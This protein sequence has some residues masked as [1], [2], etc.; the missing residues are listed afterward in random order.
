MWPP[1]GG[2]GADRLEDGRRKLLNALDG[3]KEEHCRAHPEPGSPSIQEALAVLVAFERL[4]TRAVES[5]APP[6][7]PGPR[8]EAAATERVAGL[9]LPALIH[10]LN[11]ARNQAIRTLGTLP[12]ESR[13]AFEAAVLQQAERAVQRIERNAELLGLR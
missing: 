11:A 4:A 2:E 9:M 12:A 1:Q 7:A 13:A 5:G 3:L 8:D 10:D 6:P